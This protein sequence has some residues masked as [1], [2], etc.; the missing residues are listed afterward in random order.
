MYAIIPAAGSSLRYNASN[1]GQHSHKLLERLVGDVTVIETTVMRV[2]SCS[3]IV[4]VVM[5]VS[6]DIRPQVENLLND[7]IKKFNLPFIF[8]KGGKTRQ[9]SVYYALE[10]V[11]ADV[12]TVLVHDAARPVCSAKDFSKIVEAGKETGS[13]LLARPVTSTIK[14]QVGSDVSSPL[15]VEETVDRSG[16]WEAETPQVFNRE[17]LLSAHRKAIDQKMIATDDSSL[18]ERFGGKVEIIPAESANLKITSQFDLELARKML[19]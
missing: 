8:L 6:D 16:L 15:I 2:C 14:Q 17:M 9:E 11:P 1:P 5:P 10:V 3:E 13:A 19:N 4:G 18:V 12:E 7:F